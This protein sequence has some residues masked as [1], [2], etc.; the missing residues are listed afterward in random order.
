M[1]TSPKTSTKE[2][3]ST[4]EVKVH[5]LVH[6]IPEDFFF[7]D[8]ISRDISPEVSDLDLIDSAREM[9][10]NVL[11]AGPTGSAKTSLVYAAAARAGLPVVNVP[12]N[13][14]AEPRQFIGGWTPT[15][16]GKFDFVPGD[17]VT[18]VQH[19]GII[20]LDEVNMLPPKIAAFLHGLLDRRRTVTLP[21]A[22]GSSLES[23]EIRAHELCQVVAAYNP[24]YHGTRPLN[25]AFK[26]R[27]AIKIDF[28]YDRVVEEKLVLSK[29]LLNFADSLRLN[30]DVGD[31]TTPI[32]TNMLMEFEQ[33]AHNDALGFDFAVANF[34]GTFTPEEQTV[35]REVLVLE[36]NNIWG[37]LFDGEYNGNLVVVAKDT[38]GGE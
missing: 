33:F 36:A 24:N 26:N 10:H 7:D 38:E 4:T 31:I 1:A 11:I 32:S 15:A 8:Y 19:G 5:P 2:A 13:G 30:F 25:Q 16:D 34:I 9:G 29:A 28:P 3:A 6:L 37:D 20:Y 27:F 35:V 17:L 12:C 23:T 18:A 22:K 21:D 14:A